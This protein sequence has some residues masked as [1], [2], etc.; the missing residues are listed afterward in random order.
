MTGR[1]AHKHILTHTY[2]YNLTSA[3]LLIAIR[4]R[5][6]IDFNF[7]PAT[8][9]SLIRC[10][11]TKER[12]KKK[13]KKK[14]RDSKVQATCLHEIS[15]QR[16]SMHF[17]I[18]ITRCSRPSLMD[19][20]NKNIITSHKSNLSILRLKENWF[21]SVCRIWN[22]RSSVRK[23]GRSSF[24]RYF[25]PLFATAPSIFAPYPFS[26]SSLFFLRRHYRLALCLIFPEVVRSSRFF[27]RLVCTAKTSGASSTSSPNTAE[28]EEPAWHRSLLDSWYMVPSLALVGSAATRSEF[29]IFESAEIV[30]CSENHCRET[31]SISAPDIME[32]TMNG[33]GYNVT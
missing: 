21:G 27:A 22:G 2:I 31:D 14:K 24:A 23:H 9:I 11:E 17:C 1:I 33:T 18:P 5:R 16:V 20:A 15:M 8:M 13:K 4:A 10:P 3:D 28:E 7:L 30:V 19:R 29:T 26:L 12:E 32:Y 6:A 25:R